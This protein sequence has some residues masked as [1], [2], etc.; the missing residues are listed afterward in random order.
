LLHETKA[1]IN[2]GGTYKQTCYHTWLRKNK[3]N[4]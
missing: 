3:N 4:G 2:D 1:Y